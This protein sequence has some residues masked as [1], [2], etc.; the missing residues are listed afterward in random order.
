MR[1]AGRSE[2]RECRLSGH[3]N[4]DMEWV[5]GTR[6]E[7][8]GCIELARREDFSK[9]SYHFERAGQYLDAW[10]GRFG[11]PFSTTSPQ[12]LVGYS[13]LMMQGPTENARAQ[14]SEGLLRTIDLGNFAHQ[15]RARQCQAVFYECQGVDSMAKFHRDKALELVQQ[16]QLAGWHQ[17]LNRILIPPFCSKSR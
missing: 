13:L 6:H 1:Q 16:H 2:K 10:I 15:I 14:I 4:A 8:L 7:A 17:M 11:I 12:S 3:L 9:A 5:E